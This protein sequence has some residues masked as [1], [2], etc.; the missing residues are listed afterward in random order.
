[1][2]FLGACVMVKNE[3]ATMERTITSVKDVVDILIILDTGST[4]GTQ[5]FI[6]KTCKKWSLKCIIYESEWIDFASC[7][8]KLLELSR[9]HCR[10]L[11]LL[12]ANE[13]I[14]DAAPLK[15]F[16]QNNQNDHLFSVKYHIT[17]ELYQGSI[18]IFD[19]ISIIRNDVEIYYVGS[20]HEALT[21]D[22]KMVYTNNRYLLDTNFHILNDRKK[23]K[24]SEKRFIR[25]LALL[26]KELDEV[27]DPQARTL[28]YLG[29]TYACLKDYNKSRLYYMMLYHHEVAVKC[30]SA[31]V[32]VALT[33]TF[34]SC[35]NVKFLGIPSW[36]EYPC[37]V[38]WY[39]KDGQLE[40]DC[41]KYIEMYERT[42][43]FDNNWWIML[44]P[45]LL[46]FKFALHIK[47]YATC[48]KY[49]NKMVSLAEPHNFVVSFYNKQ[50]YTHERWKLIIK[51]LTDTDKTKSGLYAYA[52][53]VYKKVIAADVQAQQQKS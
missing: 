35:L 29:Q 24:S 51:Y 44:E 48:E 22:K 8:N 2:E 42:L 36:V 33:T 40:I 17:N 53:D 12:D 1:M 39:V 21:T 18:S 27:E 6:K 16:L 49:L 43:T 10:F 19:R 5:K 26:H 7:R 46:V 50:L 34:Q 13:V 38:F 11:L 30:Y 37:E 32:I 4:D 41:D 45:Y 47:D 52:M 14:M 25:D 31:F 15:Q 28:Y 3:I 23:D 9:K 20:V